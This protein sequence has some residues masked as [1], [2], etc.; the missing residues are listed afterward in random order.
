[1]ATIFYGINVGA[2]ESTVSIASTTTGKDVEVAINST[3]NVSSRD[4][5]AVALERI[6]NVVDQSAFT[7]I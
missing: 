2:E 1:M 3:A 4:L 6:K 7:P 5:L